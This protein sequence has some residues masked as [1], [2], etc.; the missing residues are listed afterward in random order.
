MDSMFSQASNYTGEGIWSWDV[1]KVTSMRYTFWEATSFVGDLSTW[2]A[3]KVQDLSYV[4][5]FATSFNSVSVPQSC[6]P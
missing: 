1:S 4:F 3:S 6:V 2:D 5:A